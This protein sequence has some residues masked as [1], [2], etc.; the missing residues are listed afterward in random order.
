MESLRK[1]I[2]YDTFKLVVAIVL[3]ILWIILLLNPRPGRGGLPAFPRAAF[4]WK[5]DAAGQ[6]LMDPQGRAV[7]ALE[8]GRQEWQPLVPAE[9]RSQAGAGHRVVKGAADGWTLHG[10]D[11]KAQFRWDAA[12]MRWEPLKAA[13]VGEAPPVKA[14]ATPAAQAVSATA[15]PLPA[16][17]A[18]PEATATP[19]PSA[20]PAPT[21]TPEVT[22]TPAPVE[23]PAA[24]PTAAPLADTPAAPA[25][26]PTA[27]AGL[28]A[29]GDCKAAA[30]SR[31][32]VGKMAR[33]VSNLNL[34]SSPQMGKNVIKVNPA[35]TK[36]NVIGGP[37]CMTAQG[38]AYL[39][40]QVS[41]ADGQQGW[42]AEATLN[43]RGYFL[44]PL[45]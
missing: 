10:A 1:W 33:V 45:P 8:A 29:A 30:P 38:G 21:S 20:T 18:T 19:Q 4:E 16:A 35:G 24:T 17:G 36:L 32:A 11:G 12:A 44:Q 6:A 43:G 34:R 39:W 40:W 2:G 7:Y 5:Y 42:S 28:A 3:L 15:S 26:T 23:A 22:V 37:V 41:T 13:A 25:N 14:T 31:L 9:V 27:A